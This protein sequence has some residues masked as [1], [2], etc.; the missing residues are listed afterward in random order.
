[1]STKVAGLAVK[2][3]YTNVRVYLEGQPAW[4]KAHNMVYASKGTIEKGNIVLVDLR[5]V[6]KSEAGRIARSVTIPYDTFDDRIDDIPLKAPVVLYSDSAEDAAAAV[7]DLRDEGYKKVALVA[8]NYAGWVKAGGATVKEPVV[9][10][11]TWVRKLGKGEVSAEDFMKVANG[12]DKE[13]V[14]LDVRTSDEVVDGSFKGSIA[15]PLDQVGARLT[16]IPKDK[17]IYV[18]CTTGARADMAAQELKKNGYK[19][20]FLVADVECEEDSCEIVD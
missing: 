4:I 1:M 8:G 13:A 11:L 14:I 15:V 18:H 10:E 17:I 19:A 20:F 2:D 7:A 5:S 3:G 9:T 12:E 6:K 16:D